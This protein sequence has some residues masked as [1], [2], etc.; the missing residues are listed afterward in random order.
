MRDSI[1]IA[2]LFYLTICS[3]VSYAQNSENYKEE[4]LSFISNGNKISGRLMS[5]PAES[6]QKL[7]VVVFVHGSGPEDFSASG[8]YGYLFEKFTE[9]GF[10]CFSWDRPGVGDSEGK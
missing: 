2:V 5:P 10:A 8:N 9:I 7:P 6:A 1:K 3:G 4:D